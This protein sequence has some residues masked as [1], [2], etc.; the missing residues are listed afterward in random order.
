MTTRVPDEYVV[1]GLYWSKRGEIACATHAPER[2]SERWEREQW[3]EITAVQSATPHYQC[4]HC[5]GSPI[6]RS[7]PWSKDE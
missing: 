5:Y 7:L 1:E 3:S 2:G 4:Q 6:H